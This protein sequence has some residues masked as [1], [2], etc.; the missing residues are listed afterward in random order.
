[1]R[2]RAW[3]TIDEVMIPAPFD[4]RSLQ[5]KGDTRTQPEHSVSSEL[6]ASAYV[7]SQRARYGNL[8]D[9]VW[10][11]SNH[12]PVQELIEQELQAYG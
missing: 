4:L 3:L 9:A 8:E 2:V 6:Q 7:Q 11:I 12:H 5:A 10:R 1:V